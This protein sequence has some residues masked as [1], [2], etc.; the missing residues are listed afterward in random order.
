MKLEYRNKKVW[1]W[2]M[3]FFFDLMDLNL[4]SF[5]PLLDWIDENCIKWI[6]F[7]FHYYLLNWF[8]FLTEFFILR[9]FD[10]IEIKFAF[11]WKSFHCKIFSIKLHF[12]IGWPL[13]TSK[14]NSAIK[15]KYFCRAF[16]FQSLQ[17]RIWI[18]HSIGEIG[19]PMLDFEPKSHTI[20]ILRL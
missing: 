12:R 6:Q 7:D 2:W 15:T 5:S 18:L 14:K 10:W 1:H 4:K 8:D 19:K 9:E 20:Q 17:I 11:K 16:C 3:F 13:A